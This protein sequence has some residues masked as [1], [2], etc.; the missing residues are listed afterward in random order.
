MKHAIFLNK[1]LNVCVEET[2]AQKTHF[3]QFPIP[4][5]EIFIGSDTGCLIKTKPL[6]PTP[7]AKEDKRDVIK[8]INFVQGDKSELPFTFAVQC[9][10]LLLLGGMRYLGQ[11]EHHPE[12]DCAKV[13]E[14]LFN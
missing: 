1:E 2:T 7:S 3:L 14:L 5:D 6:H 11:P 4:T 9:N 12:R 8:T 10:I 13:L